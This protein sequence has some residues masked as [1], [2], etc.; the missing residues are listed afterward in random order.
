MDLHPEK[1]RFY[2]SVR[3]CGVQSLFFLVCAMFNLRIMML[4]FMVILGDQIMA[5]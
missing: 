4:V 5:I 2:D 3:G 1:L